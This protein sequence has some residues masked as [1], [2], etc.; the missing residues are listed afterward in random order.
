M[1]KKYQV[2]I[3]ST[4]TDLKDER[5]EIMEAIINLGHIPVGMELFNAADDTQW[6]VIKR[7]IEESDYYVLVI[8]DRYGSID[9]DGVGFT[10]KEYEF[11]ISIKKPIISF[12]RE[13][14]AIELL[15][16]QDRESDNKAELGLFKSKVSKRLFKK[17]DNKVDLSKKFFSAFAELIRDSPQPGWVRFNDIDQITRNQFNELF[18]TNKILSEENLKLKTQISDSEKKICEL[19][20]IEVRSRSIIEILPQKEFSIGKYS[21]NGIELVG[22]FGGFVSIEGELSKIEHS[23]INFLAMQTQDEQTWSNKN[24]SSIKYIIGSFASLGLIEVKPLQFLLH[25]EKS[26]P[27]TVSKNEDIKFVE[28][29]KPTPLLTEVYSK[30]K[31]FNISNVFKS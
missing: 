16:Y 21:F 27:D 28:M 22:I 30:I 6:G 24:E 17:W 26:S 9:T 4:F 3:S 5:V 13:E 31:T 20:D 1:D 7:R 14:S 15:P 12:L 25:Y 2:F 11:A 8:S 29:V 19:N 23:I 18:S 10:E